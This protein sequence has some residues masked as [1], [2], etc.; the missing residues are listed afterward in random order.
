[1]DAKG[2][3]TARVQVRL[4]DLLREPDAAQT[5]VRR[6]AESIRKNADTIGAESLER[7][8]VKAVA[9]GDP[10]RRR[11]ILPVQKLDAVAYPCALRGGG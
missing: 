9:R 2:P 11:K 7:S 5:T 6:S 10:K 3:Q 4:P 1:M 8:A